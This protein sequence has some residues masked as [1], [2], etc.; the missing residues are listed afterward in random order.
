MGEPVAVKGGT[1]TVV[2]IS[3]LGLAAS[4]ADGI[5]YDDCYLEDRDNY[6]DIVLSGDDAAARSITDLEIPGLDGGY[7]PLFNPG[8]PGQTPTPGVRY[9]A[10]GPSH[11]QPVTIALDDPMRVSRD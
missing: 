4:A 3:D 7:R 8:G 11:M 10:P 6:L 5:A 2:G 1:L 9:T